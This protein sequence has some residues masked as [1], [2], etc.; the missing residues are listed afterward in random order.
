MTIWELLIDP[1]PAQFAVM[2]VLA[3]VVLRLAL[4]PQRF[5][6]LLIGCVLA[7]GLGEGLCRL[8]GL[9]K[10]EA[11]V[12]R[13][14]RRDLLSYQPGGRLRYRYPSDPRGYFGDDNEIVGTVNS[15]GF[16]GRETAPDDP[17]AVRVVMLGDS[18]LLGIGVK[19]GDTL[20]AQLE[21]ELAGSVEGVEVLNFGVTGTDTRQQIQILEERALAFDPDVVV[22][23]V[24]LNDAGQIGT[25]A[26]L[27]GSGLLAKVRRQS[28][29]LNAIVAIPD[30]A[31]LTRQMIQHYRQEFQAES[32][33]WRWV[34]ES[35]LA[36]RELARS[37]GVRFA[38][39]L[40]PVLFRLDEGYPFAEIHRTVADFCEQN[41]IPFRDLLGAFHGHQDTDLWVH[42]VDQHPNEIANRL[43]A[44]DLARF[45]LEAGLLGSKT[46]PGGTVGPGDLSPRDGR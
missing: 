14:D 20:S 24:F 12:W 30:R 40:Y 33:G 46:E 7:L 25:M 32:E 2:V 17:E 39:V 3:L 18:F 8:L 31:I 35:L 43:A 23:V 36:G 26:F 13:E 16:R 41:D 21:R 5:Y 42:R 45:L 22:L 34:R 1:S 44:Q 6:P 38:V 19:D 28:R 15:H 37:R 11:G 4:K 29:L 10:M 27:A 9:G